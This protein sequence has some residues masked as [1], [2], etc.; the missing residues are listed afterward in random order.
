MKMYFKYVKLPELLYHYCI[1]LILSDVM[2]R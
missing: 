1:I 2:I